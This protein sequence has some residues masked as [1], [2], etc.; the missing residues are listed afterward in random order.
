MVRYNQDVDCDSFAILLNQGKVVDANSLIYF[1]HLKHPSG[2]I[3]HSGDNT[4]GIGAGDD[5]RIHIDLS[6]INCESII[7]GVNI[8]DA[9]LKNQ[10]FGLIENA[11]VRLVDEK[12]NREICRYSLNTQY[13]GF[14]TVI[15]GELMNYNGQWGFTA[16]GQPIVADS[17]SEIGRMYGMPSQYRSFIE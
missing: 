16:I 5:E 6:R 8:Y 15:M 9:A 2:A 14:T 4:S 13:S 3:Y 12:F 1:G 7:I 10:H 17:I 11:F